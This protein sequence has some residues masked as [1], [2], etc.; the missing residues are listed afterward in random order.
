MGIKKGKYLSKRLLN[1]LFSIL[2]LYIWN[3]IAIGATVL[4]LMIWGILYGISLSINIAIPDTLRPTA[5]FNSNGLADLG[6]S[7]W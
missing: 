4:T 5:S 1:L 3:G 2:G 6:Y 7:Y